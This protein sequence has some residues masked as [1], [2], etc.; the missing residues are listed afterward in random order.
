MRHNG[1]PSAFVP[2]EVVTEGHIEDAKKLLSASRAYLD[3]DEPLDAMAVLKMA[4]SHCAMA[5]IYC[6]AVEKTEEQ[7]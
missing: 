7:A 5:D 6:S 2:P 3:H 1:Y 4:F